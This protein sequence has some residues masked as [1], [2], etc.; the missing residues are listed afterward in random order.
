MGFTSSVAA[1]TES[2]HAGD[3]YAGETNT[4]VECVKV[5]RG[6]LDSGGKTSAEQREKAGVL[7][8]GEFRGAGGEEFL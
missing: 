7:A 5:R 6:E 4:F 1:G 3:G 8:P 2:H